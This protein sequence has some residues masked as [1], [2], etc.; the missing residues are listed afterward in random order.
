MTY[1]RQTNE[2]YIILNA[3]RL[4]TRV[5]KDVLHSKSYNVSPLTLS[6]RTSALF[7]TL[8]YVLGNRVI[9]FIATT[10]I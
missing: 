5:I 10:R 3:H 6:T 9:L 8:Y 2:Q 7:N 1:K 4:T